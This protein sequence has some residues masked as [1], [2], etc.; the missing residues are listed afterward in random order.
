M[1]DVAERAGVTKPTLYK[2]FGDKAAIYRESLQW[3]A[4][5]AQ[6]FLI[7]R[8]TRAPHTSISAEVA[9]D[10][11]A[12]FDYARA[13]P[14]GFRLLL[15]LTDSG[16]GSDIRDELVDNLTTHLAGR[17]A[18]HLG[19][20]EPGSALRQVA[21]MIIGASIYSARQSIAGPTP[22][23]GTAS[24]LASTFIAGGLEALTA[25]HVNQSDDTSVVR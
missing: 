9:A 11:D 15:E 23:P 10:V 3:E 5:R 20:G 17:M 18:D 7:D 16:P 1:A 6:T 14:A 2:Y 8:Y 12:F 13:H 19:S 4:S 25:L 21:A 24:A 22:D